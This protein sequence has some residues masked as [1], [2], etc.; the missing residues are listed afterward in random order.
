VTPKSRKE[1]ILSFLSHGKKRR[2]EIIKYIVTIESSE[3][4]YVE[5]AVDNALS[6]LQDEGEIEKETKGVYYRTDKGSNIIR[7][8]A[9]ADQDEVKHILTQLEH[10][11]DILSEDIDTRTLDKKTKP[12][13]L[14]DLLE[15]EMYRKNILHTEENVYRFSD[16]FDTYTH[17][18]IDRISIDDNEKEKF[19]SIDNIIEYQL[20]FQLTSGL[21][22]NAQNG[23]EHTELLPEIHSHIQTLSEYSRQ[24]PPELGLEVQAVARDIYPA[25]GREVFLDLIKESLYDKNILAE[26]AFYTYDVHNEINELFS[27]LEEVKA[28]S[29]N[30]EEKDRIKDLI[31]YITN[32]Y[33]D[34][35]K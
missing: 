9:S 29:V 7:P 5:D 6:N 18:L 1:A 30:Q 34:N 31:E 17:R 22:M 21:I 35:V 2:Q 26:M 11:L 15:I 12:E 33:R 20:L 32:I 14:E 10:S 24:L 27:D 8:K 28:N 13:L 4:R 19:A 3:K 23:Q 25:I 16:I